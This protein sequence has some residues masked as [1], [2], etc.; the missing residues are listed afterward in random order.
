MGILLKS[1]SEVV[2]SGAWNSA[3]GKKLWSDADAAGLRITLSNEE[4]LRIF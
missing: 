2:M 4:P 3:F 1:D